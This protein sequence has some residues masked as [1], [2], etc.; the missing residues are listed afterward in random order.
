MLEMQEDMNTLCTHICTLLCY[1]TGHSRHF[2]VQC[3]STHVMLADVQIL[4]H[5][6]L[7]N[8]PVAT[9]AGNFN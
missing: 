1:T 5:I 2:N 4:A 8:V 3:D 7:M 6:K 9:T